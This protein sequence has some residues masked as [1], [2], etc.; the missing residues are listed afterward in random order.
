MPH[1]DP[2]HK[3]TII[4]RAIGSL[5]FTMQLPLEDESLQSKPRAGRPTR[6][7]ARRPRRRGADLRQITT[8]AHND[9]ERATQI[10]RHMVYEFGMSDRLG[11]VS[12]VAVRPLL[13]GDGF[14]GRDLPVSEATAEVLDAEVAAL[15][16][17][18][19]ERAAEMLRTHRTGL[20]RLAIRL[21]DRET[22]DGD[23]LARALSDAMQSPDEPARP[24][25][26][27]AAR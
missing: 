7:A 14:L 8:G 1:A 19:H 25:E 9:I 20:E 12:Y 13:P 4:P 17:Q 18:A 16:R 26:Q 15:V 5:G 6:S 23:E 11:P 24:A 2:V 21:R 3:I 27:R 22:L 10:A